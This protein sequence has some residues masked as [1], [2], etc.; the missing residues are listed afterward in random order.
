MEMQQEDYAQLGRV[1][2]MN[3]ETPAERLALMKHA[4]SAIRQR[5]GDFLTKDA[6]SSNVGESVIY[7][8]SV[9]CSMSSAR[10]LKANKRCAKIIVTELYADLFN[11]VRTKYNTEHVTLKSR[12]PHYLKP[13]GTPQAGVLP[14]RLIRL[15]PNVAYSFNPSNGCLETRGHKEQSFE[16]VYEFYSEG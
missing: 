14:F 2:K 13:L 12:T 15:E 5:L 8:T 6:S 3:H 10:G 11:T 16:V 9:L 1:F 7:A 4:K